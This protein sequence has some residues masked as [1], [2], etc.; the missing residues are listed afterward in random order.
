MKSTPKR[1]SSISKQKQGEVPSEKTTTPAQP[2]AGVRSSPRLR[3]LRSPKVRAADSPQ[4]KP[5]AASKIKKKSVFEKIENP[6]ASRSLIPRSPSSAAANRRSSLVENRAMDEFS[7]DISMEEEKSV[8][9]ESVD[10]S[11]DES[12][13]E[14]AKNNIAEKQVSES[15]LALPE[16]YTETKEE[17][18]LSMDMDETEGDADQSME[19]ESSSFVP[20]P[21]FLEE[22]EG[23]NEEDH[24][25]QDTDSLP[26]MLSQVFQSE[27][28]LDDKTG[29]ISS[30]FNFEPVKVS[31]LRRSEVETIL[32]RVQGFIKIWK[33]NSDYDERFEYMAQ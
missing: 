33:N 18:Q 20:E 11:V 22:V 16:I 27:G 12:V 28:M 26:N 15:K 17:E 9:E 24:T 6:F 1:S 2:P 23:I 29:D 7:P 30:K 10:K 13:E 4:I 19:N 14:S 32:N 31:K 21:Q 25:N 3:H 8:R 5:A